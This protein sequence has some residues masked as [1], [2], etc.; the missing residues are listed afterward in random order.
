M[1]LRIASEELRSSYHLAWPLFTD[2]ELE[3]SVNHL[4]YANEQPGVAVSNTSDGKEANESDYH[5]YE[6]VDMC[7]QTAAVSGYDDIQ[8]PKASCL[9]PEQQQL[10]ESDDIYELTQCPAYIP[11]TPMI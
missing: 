8:A 7:H 3:E 1:I 5:E 2:V 10:S 11:V 9:N 4:Q 6:I